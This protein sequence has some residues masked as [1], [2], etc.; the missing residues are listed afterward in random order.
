MRTNYSAQFCLIL[1]C[2]NIFPWLEHVYF[3][4]P[5]SKEKNIS[6]MILKLF[7]IFT[8]SP[9]YVLTSTRNL[10]RKFPT[11]E[12][13]Q[14]IQHFLFGQNLFNSVYTKL[15]ISWKNYSKRLPSKKSKF[16]SVSKCK[17]LSFFLTPVLIPSNN[18][19]QCQKTCNIFKWYLQYFFF[20]VIKIT[21]A[22]SYI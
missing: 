20:K 4:L 14:T 5:T 21:S 10:Q 8:L 7:N 22:I 2:S 9:L 13:F 1:K 15:N 17:C 16:S 18:S 6:W 11:M 12:M 3:L 19:F